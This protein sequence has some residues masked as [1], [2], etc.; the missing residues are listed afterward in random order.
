RVTRDFTRAKMQAHGRQE[1]RISQWQLDRLANKKTEMQLKAAAYKVIPQA[2]NI[3]SDNGRLPA[4]RRQIMYAAR[5]LVKALTGGK[6]WEDT[7][8]FTQVVLRDFMNDNP[9]LTQDW[10]V[11]ADARGHFSEPHVRQRIGIGTLEVRGYTKSW[12][13]A[14]DLD[15]KIDDTFPTI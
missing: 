13:K 4:N 14:P 10:D 9:E 15:I 5:P 1:E 2:Y 6:F 12:E 8:T 3:V 7:Q 11:V